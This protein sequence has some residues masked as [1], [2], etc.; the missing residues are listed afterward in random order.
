MAGMATPQQLD[1]L[2]NSKGK[3]FDRL[4]LN[5]MIN[6]HDGAIKMVNE[7]R[8]QSGSAYDPV[9]NEFVTDLYN[10]QGVEIERM[11]GLLIGLN[12]VMQ[13]FRRWVHGFSP[14]VQVTGVG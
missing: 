11:N 4:F 6:H 9:L 14:R 8:K 1:A 13:M 10:D 5:L 3:D 12:L 7:L 2:E